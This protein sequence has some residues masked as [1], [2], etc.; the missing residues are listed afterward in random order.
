L[1]LEA[2]PPRSSFNHPRASSRDQFFHRRKATDGDLAQIQDEA[3]SSYRTYGGILVLAVVMFLLP[4][5]I[6]TILLVT[7]WLTLIG[8]LS[9]GP[10]RVAK[11]MRRRWSALARYRPVF[12]R[13][14]Q[15][16]AKEA[17]PKVDRCID[18]FPVS[19]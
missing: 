13:K 15:K 6:P 7:F 17:E 4:L 9:V 16:T 10:A 14:L 8:Y 3:F 11:F 2:K 1:I 12:A 5:L 18:Q 19:L